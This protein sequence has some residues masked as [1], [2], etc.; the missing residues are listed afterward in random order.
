M[1]KF[2]LIIVLF[3]LF[4][5]IAPLSAGDNPA[6]I[7]KNGQ[8]V[9]LNTVFFK[10]NGEKIQ[11]KQLLNDTPIIVL[12]VY[13]SCPNVCNFLMGSVASIVKELGVKP[14]KDYRIIS[15]SFDEND[16]PTIAMNKKV[17]FI[18]AAGKDFPDD[19]WV[20]LTSDKKNIK[21]FM[22]SIGFY[23]KPT[24]KDFLH[25]VVTVIVNPDGKISRYLY[26]IRLLPFDVTMAVME[27]QKGKS[28]LSIKRVLTYCFSYDPKGKK[29][30]FNILRVS[31]TIIITM[32]I[33]LGIY[34]FYLSKKRKK[35]QI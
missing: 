13:Y 25:P 6:I 24:G 3:I 28:G 29:Y 22:D 8:L 26:G 35:E 19:G 15:V 32:L 2:L 16:T 10:E 5:W 31:G 14:T 23:F 21:E 20:F 34:L 9:A 30:V 12:P 4:L 11:F 18:Q 27:S 1:K 17:N 33:F 7:E